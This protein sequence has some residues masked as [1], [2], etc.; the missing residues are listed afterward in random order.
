MLFRSPGEWIPTPVF[1][2][3]KPHGHRSLAG[4][5]PQ[6]RKECDTAEATGTCI[7]PSKEVEDTIMEGEIRTEKYD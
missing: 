5:S 4:Y 7:S 6:G 3:E 1:L 2:P